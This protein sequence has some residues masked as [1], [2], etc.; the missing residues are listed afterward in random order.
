MDLYSE[1]K[2]LFEDNHCLVLQKP[3]RIP[4][5]ADDSYDLSLLAW[6]KK[7]R[8]DSL[9]GAAKG[10]VAPVHFIDRP[11]S[12]IVL[13]AKSSKAASRF[14]EQFRSRS[15]D[16]RYIAVVAGTIAVGTKKVLRDHLVKDGVTNVSRVSSSK[17]RE[18]KSCEL[19][20]EC[21]STEGG[22]SLLEVLPV[23]GRSHQIRVQLSNDGHPIF[24]D[25]K[26][27]A[28]ETWGGKI[29]L[30]AYELN[31]THPTSKESK[32]VSSFP[33]H[34]MAEQRLSTLLNQCARLSRMPST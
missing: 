12:G 2:I 17:D 8:E 24:G 27:G 20:Y 7:Y 16:K 25:A 11:V 31:F 15:I 4:V 14:S 19:S 23:T 6:A 9:Q 30:H 28:K 33:E 21:V 10:F 26:Y 3:S 29:A 1:I 5:A 18:A 32:H 13:F 34:W 22:W